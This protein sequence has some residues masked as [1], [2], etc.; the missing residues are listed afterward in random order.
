MRAHAD[1]SEAPESAPSTREVKDGFCGHS[2]VDPDH[3]LTDNA[4]MRRTPA[5]A[6]VLSGAAGCFYDYP[7][8]LPDAEVQLDV[9][10]ADG[11]PAKL[12]HAHI[13]GTE[14]VAEADG[15]GHVVFAGLPVL[16]SVIVV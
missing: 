10:D 9:V 8:Q 13:P 1:S 2:R 16:D 5:L 3:G 12:A 11:D 6:L 15:K 14:R 7:R 4:P